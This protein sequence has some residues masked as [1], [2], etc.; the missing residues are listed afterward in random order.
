MGGSQGPVSIFHEAYAGLLTLGH[1]THRGG[2]ERVATP[3]TRK[4]AR[5]HLSVN[6]IVPG[7][8]KGGHGGVDRQQ[9][10]MF[11]GRV[12]FVATRPPLFRV[13]KRIVLDSVNKQS[14]EFFINSIDDLMISEIVLICYYN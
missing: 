11:K 4:L 12:A 13:K 10:P 1:R 9:V 5:G 8:S 14:R 7:C 3:S 2:V 6:K